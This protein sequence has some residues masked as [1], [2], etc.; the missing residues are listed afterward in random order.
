MLNWYLQ[1]GK[2]SDVVI[3]SKIR[4]A[5]NFS[6]FNF[7]IKEE[8]IIKLE[9]QIQES[10]VPI[11]YGLKLF[12]L[13]DIDEITLQELIE[14][15]L[16]PIEMVRNKKTT[17]ILIN[18]DE[19]ICILINGEDHLQLQVFTSGL[20][21][22]AITNL[23]I[24]I[25]EKIQTLFDIA[26]SPKYGYL[27]ACPTNVGTGMKISVMLHLPG[28]IKTNNIEKATK[29]VR[30]FG[31]EIAKEQNPDIYRICNERTLGITEADIV[32]QVK[33]ITEKL[34]EQERVAR[35]I[36]TENIID[37]ED[38]IFRSYGI[39]SNCRKICQS[40][41]EELLSKIKLGTDLGIIT[42]L[43]D[44]KVKRLYFYIK[45]ANLNKYFGQELSVEEQ[46]I[47]RA[48]LIKQI[49]KD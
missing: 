33:S 10:L 46:N 39:L 47:K 9:N 2:D 12:K 38:D 26:K 4:L 20:E 15:R 17:S 32:K 29:F 16:I 11:G 48:E 8:E 6:Q 23:C 7:Y 43:T 30:Q 41:A 49:T 35:K 34:I 28:L 44:A 13:R 45:P 21:I 18:D 19:N 24:E 14:K 36:L 25:D 40:E 5:R 1:T 42:N 27:T 3:A 31:I 22:D 37:L